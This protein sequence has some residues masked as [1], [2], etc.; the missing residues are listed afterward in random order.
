MSV[1]LKKRV[2]GNSNTSGL[3]ERTMTSIIPMKWLSKPE[4]GWNGGKNFKKQIGVWFWLWA[5]CS[6][7]W[8]GIAISL[9][10]NM[11]GY[12]LYDSLVPLILSVALTLGLLFSSI[13]R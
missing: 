7:V 1:S 11:F 8:T 3:I 2:A 13:E 4:L 10:S 9:T 6:V 5:T 12:G